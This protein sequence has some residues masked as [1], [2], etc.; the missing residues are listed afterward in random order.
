MSNTIITI[1]RES[2]SGGGVV[3]RLLGQELGL[4]VYNRPIL[5]K[6]AEHFNMSVEEI[7]KVCAQR[8]TWWDDICRFYQQFAAVSYEPGRQTTATPESIYHVEERLLH[9]LAEEESCIIVGRAANHVFRDYP[10]ALRLLLIADRDFRTANLMKYKELTEEEAAAFIDR[11][12]RDRDN[13]VRTVTGSSRY[14]ARAYDFVFNIT[15]QEP[16]TVARF[17]ADNIRLWMKK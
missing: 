9:A 15:G 12:D 4:K 5:D 7:E 14:D 13:Y 16:E 2:G 11:R 10:Q 3:A 17:L 6:L 8:N 1:A